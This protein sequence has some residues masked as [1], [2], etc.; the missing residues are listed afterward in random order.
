MGAS[1]AGTGPIAAAHRL[2]PAAVAFGPLSVAGLAWMD[3]AA[4]LA[5]LGG[6]PP[7]LIARAH[8]S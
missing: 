5:L 3:F 8:R 4:L 1:R 6:A 2:L 7:E